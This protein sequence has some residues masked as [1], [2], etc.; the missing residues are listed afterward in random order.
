MDRD[1]E[2]VECRLR[3]ILSDPTPIN[4]FNRLVITQLQDGELGTEVTV[5]SSQS[6]G[7]PWSFS[8]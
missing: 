6:P 8:R 5:R 3:T 2:D 1:W 7:K 4:H